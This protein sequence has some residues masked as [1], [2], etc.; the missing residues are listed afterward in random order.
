MN[1]RLVIDGSFGEGGGQIVRSSLALSLVTGRPFI[2][3][4]LRARRQRPG[5]MKQHLTAV[6]AAA[7]VG[8]AKVH[9]AE[10]GSSR[11]EF[12]PGEV[13]PGEYDFR[14]G[15]A[16]STTLVAQTVLPALLHLAGPSVLH[17]E[18]GTHNPLAPPYD[19]LEK[20][21]LPLVARMGPTIRCTLAR[22]GFYPAGGGGFS[23]AVQPAPTLGGL[24]LM[25]R[26]ALVSCRVRGL[27]ANLP[28]HIAERECNTIAQLS[29][30]DEAC[31]TVE[32]VAAAGPGNVVLIELEHEHVTEVFAGVG[33]KG[34]KAEAIASRAWR[35]AQAYLESGVPVGEHL[36]DQ[37]LLPLGLAAWQYR[38]TSRYRTG[39]LSQHA[40]THI[41]ILRMFLDVPIHVDD[42]EGGAG[43]V[44][45]GDFERPLRS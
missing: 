10:I 29:G 17:V 26:G 19:F 21:Y 24:D 9:G 23:I 3:E 22:H 16:G 7:E 42:S 33:Q 34:V 15:T 18:G 41:E 20:T 43:A 2:I 44:T 40:H 12:E 36:A 28:R 32:Q 6:K 37:L 11:L 5:L 4:N 8:Q 35:E 31:F 39:P 13:K 45:V 27:V 1:D 14:I 30:W 25:D 38:A